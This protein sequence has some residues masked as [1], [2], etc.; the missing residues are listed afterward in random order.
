MRSDSLLLPSELS[1]NVSI[2]RGENGEV[3]YYARPTPAAAN[4]AAGFAEPMGVGGFNPSSVYINEVCAVTTPR[5]GEMD[6]VEFYNGGDESV[7]LTGWHISDSKRELQKFE[8]SFITVP[9][10]GYAVLSCSG[11]STE[12]QTTP[13]RVFFTKPARALPG[14]TSRIWSTPSSPRR[15]S[16]SSM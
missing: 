3:L 10:K 15:R 16:V 5:S 4:T 2:G 8:L 12:A 7:T 11:V 9:A 1:A 13:G 6:W 14:P